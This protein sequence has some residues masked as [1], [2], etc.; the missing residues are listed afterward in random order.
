MSVSGTGAPEAGVKQENTSRG[1]G[2][3]AGAPARTNVLE[4]EAAPG[5]SDLPDWMRM[6]GQRTFGC[7]HPVVT[8]LA[9]QV[10]ALSGLPARLRDETTE[11]AAGKLLTDALQPLLPLLGLRYADGLPGVPEAW[12]GVFLEVRDPLLAWL[13]ERLGVT[14]VAPM[15]GEAF[16]PRTMEVTETPPDS[17]RAGK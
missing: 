9:E 14:V 13:S 4:R 11:E 16:D 7:E 15:R 5:L 17:P 2:E 3:G 1:A 6:L 8:S 12:G 10:S